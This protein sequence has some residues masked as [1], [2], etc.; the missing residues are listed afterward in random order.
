[1]PKETYSLHWIKNEN[2]KNVINKYLDE[3][4]KLIEKQKTDLEEF[5]PYKKN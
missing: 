4:V 2:F 1:M 5:A 3:E